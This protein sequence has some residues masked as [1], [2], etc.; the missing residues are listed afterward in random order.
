[1]NFGKEYVEKSNNIE[2]ERGKGKV[3]RMSYERMAAGPAIPL[4][5]EFMKKEHPDMECILEKG[6]DAKTPDEINSHNI[7]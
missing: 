6:D 7:V 4:I 2:N 5:Y 1:M 3:N